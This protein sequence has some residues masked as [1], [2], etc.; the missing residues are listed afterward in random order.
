MKKKNSCKTN[1]LNSYMKRR[2]KI[3]GVEWG[4]SV[5]HLNVMFE[6]GIRTFFG[7]TIDNQGNLINDSQEPYPGFFLT[8]KI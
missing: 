1:K 5:Q 3:E 4:L 6:L 8:N 7:V 2:S